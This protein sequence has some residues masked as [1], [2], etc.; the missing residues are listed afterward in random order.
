M[1]EAISTSHKLTVP[2]KIEISLWKIKLQNAINATGLPSIRIAL[3]DT[4]NVEWYTPLFYRLYCQHSIEFA[5]LS[6]PIEFD[7][8]F[9]S[10]FVMGM[11]CV[12]VYGCVCLVFVHE[13]TFQ[14]KI[15][16]NFMSFIHFVWTSTERIFLCFVFDCHFT[17]HFFSSHSVC[18][19][20]VGCLFVQC[21]FW[22]LALSFN[23]FWRLFELAHEFLMPPLLN[24]ICSTHG[25]YMI[26]PRH[27][28]S[29]FSIRF[30]FLALFKN[31]AK[32][33]ITLKWKLSISRA[34]FKWFDRQSHIVFSGD[35]NFRQE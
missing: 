24:D 20:F 9:D 22:S 21:S 29:I 26:K 8:R 10:F 4:I 30:I 31:R 19:M 6:N 28:F 32:W 14:F 27:S 25:L 18:C 1:C 16:R 2:M 33:F 11:L 7:H 12:C 5:R 13:F 17:F 3:L 23:L 34:D 35:T 15:N